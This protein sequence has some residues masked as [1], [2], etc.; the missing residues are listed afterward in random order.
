LIFGTPQEQ[1]EQ[2][3]MLEKILWINLK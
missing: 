1:I 3:K 2:I